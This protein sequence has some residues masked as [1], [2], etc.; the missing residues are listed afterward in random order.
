MITLKSHWLINILKPKNVEIMKTKYRA[1]KWFWEIKIKHDLKE[2]PIIL[3]LGY[4]WVFIT[5]YT[6]EAISYT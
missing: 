2:I 6:I 1:S 5:Q 4:F 3:L